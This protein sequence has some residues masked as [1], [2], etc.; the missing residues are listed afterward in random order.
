MK[1]PNSF[2]NFVA[3]QQARRKQ[4]ILLRQQQQQAVSSSSPSSSQSSRK[5]CQ[6]TQFIFL[7]LLFF[8]AGIVFLSIWTAMESRQFLLEQQRR[9]SELL[10]LRMTAYLQNDLYDVQ[11]KERLTVF[12]AKKR[13]LLAVNKQMRRMNMTIPDGGSDGESIFEVLGENT[14]MG[15]K[16][17]GGGSNSSSKNNKSLSS[18]SLENLFQ[19]VMSE[20]PL[21]SHSRTEIM[22]KLILRDD[23]NWTRILHDE[24]FLEQHRRE[25][26]RIER[27]RKFTQ[28]ENQKELRRLRKL[29]T[30]IEL[31]KVT[32]K[33]QL[34][35][36]LPRRVMSQ[37]R[38]HFPPVPVEE[39]KSCRDKQQQQ[40]RKE[41]NSSSDNEKKNNSNKSIDATTSY[42]FPSHTRR[43]KS[44]RPK[45]AVISIAIKNETL[46]ADNT[47]RRSIMH[48]YSFWN[49]LQ[50]CKLHNYDFI[51][52]GED[53][54]DASR[55]PHWSK[56]RVLRKWLPFYDWIVYMDLDTLFTDFEFEFE[57]LVNDEIQRLL[58]F[59]LSVQEDLAGIKETKPQQQQTDNKT[60]NASG[61]TNMNRNNISSSTTSSSSVEREFPPFP[62]F[63]KREIDLIMTQ[64]QNGLNSG[65][66]VLRNSHW[67]RNFL[68]RC[69]GVPTIFTRP[70]HDQGSFLYLLDTSGKYYRDPVEAAIDRAHV[71]VMAD[72]LLNAYP[73]ALIMEEHD[74]HYQWRRGRAVMHFAGCR[75]FPHCM[76]WLEHHYFLTLC[77]NTHII[78]FPP[79]NFTPP[80]SYLPPIGDDDDDEEQQQNKSTKTQ[81]RRNIPTYPAK[82]EELWDV[83]G[84]GRLHPDFTQY[85]MNK[86]TIMT[87]HG[88]KNTRS[89]KKPNSTSE[90]DEDSLLHKSH[91]DDENNEQVDR[92]KRGLFGGKTKVHHNNNIINGHAINHNTNFINSNNHGRNY[93]INNNKMRTRKVT[94]SSNSIWMRSSRR[95]R[96]LEDMEDYSVPP[97]TRMLFQG[98]IWKL[99]RIDG[100]SEAESSFLKNKRNNLLQ[101][102]HD[103]KNN[104]N[105]NNNNGFESFDDTKSYNDKYGDHLENDDENG[106]DAL[107]DLQRQKSVGDALKKGMFTVMI[108]IGCVV[109]AVSVLLCWMSYALRFRYFQQEKKGL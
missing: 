53:S 76:D 103:R 20:S 75:F 95:R 57:N 55:P 67:M 19:K 48:Q 36:P 84:A 73:N 99:D 89:K 27:P 32:L 45:I 35:Q 11:R 29:R 10:G 61:F 33:P 59:D 58:L 41:S 80:H 77:N 69:W 85:W 109:A 37:R 64:D 18:S 87:Q 4:E 83:S 8:L 62:E 88:R 40:Q 81:N 66:M 31:G 26:E 65:V 54:V 34:Q 86:W 96:M 100:K 107:Q 21:V 102:M 92:S 79:A 82:V 93:N 60:T 30:D 28:E 3:Q 1:L 52:E 68:R 7:L 15:N 72:N 49:K 98:G 90:T 70:W 106:R 13:A 74:T 22:T 5:R 6:F 38:N 104:N 56:L 71:F 9:K 105:I 51:L 17:N 23:V 78:S 16:K 97:G 42:L 2:T 14:T 46:G 47:T 24:E 94:P 25:Q 101:F 44:T 43:V 63:E 50:Y 39:V 12:T 108:T 91:D